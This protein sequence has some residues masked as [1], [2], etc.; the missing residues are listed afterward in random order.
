MQRRLA[1]ESIGKIQK[2]KPSNFVRTIVAAITCADA[3]VV[4][5][6]VDTLIAVIGCR[7]GADD[8]AGSSLAM[9]TGHRLV[10]RLF[11]LRPASQS[12][13][14]RLASNACAG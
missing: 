11:G 4:N 8:F 2:I 7:D 14:C 13:M 10:Q 1:D 12:S 9:H 6:L 5:H 3:T